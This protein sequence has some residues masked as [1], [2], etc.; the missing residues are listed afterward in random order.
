MTT[1]VDILAPTMIVE[2]QSNLVHFYSIITGPRGLNT[3]VNWYWARHNFVECEESIM[4][5]TMCMLTIVLLVI[6]QCHA[7]YFIAQGGVQRCFLEDRMVF[8]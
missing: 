6:T 2:N 5:P 4:A 3:A 8:L 7:M 1:L